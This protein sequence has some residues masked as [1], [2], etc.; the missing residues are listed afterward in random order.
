MLRY[1]GYPVVHQRGRADDQIRTVLGP[2]LL[3]PCKQQRQQLH[4]LAQTH[5]V[6]EDTPESL[7][8]HG[9]EPAEPLGLIRPQHGGQR[10]GNAV[11]GRIDHAQAVQVCG[12][13]CVLRVVVDLMVQIV[14]LIGGHRDR[15]G[16]QIGGPQS[17][18][19]RDLVDVGHIHVAHIDEG[20][21]AQPVESAAPTVA[22]QQARHVVRV[23]FVG[24]RR[25]LHEPGF[26]RKAYGD[27]RARHGG[28][29]VERGRRHHVA[30]TAQH[31]QSF[32]QQTVYRLVIGLGDGGHGTGRAREIVE[33]RLDCES[34]HLLVAHGRVDADAVEHVV[35]LVTI[36]SL[37][38]ARHPG[39]V[40]VEVKR[41]PA[42]HAHFRQQLGRHVDDQATVRRNSGFTPS[43]R[44]EPVKDR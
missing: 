11:R 10:S 15:A 28:Q 38:V 30:Q 27:R 21:V 42:G 13:A 29:S 18:I 43:W 23:D 32:G 31:R 26:H 2:G 24:D 36:M 3:V 35:M 12:E 20:A 16:F 39:A 40:A 33:H 34:L 44:H 22:R 1:L 25:Y 6:G 9:I 4:A 41:E 8:A 37:R 14:R 5:L 17:Q 19:I 7:V